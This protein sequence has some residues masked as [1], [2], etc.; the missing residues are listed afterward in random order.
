MELDEL[1]VESVSGNDVS[2]DASSDISA[3]LLNSILLELQNS[4]TRM[5]EIGQQ[6]DDFQ[7]F[8]EEY[9]EA[10]PPHE[11]TDEEK[12]VLEEKEILEL[13][14][15]ETL[16]DLLTKINDNTVSQNALIEENNRLLNSLSSNTVSE[17]S[18]SQNALMTTSLE[19]YSVTD[20]LLLVI[21]AL[22]TVFL[23]ILFMF[24]KEG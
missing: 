11:L 21:V 7:T 10:N 22:L 5:D 12:A 2:S 6:Q 1:N 24:R 13:E 19:D 18:V 4:N 17:N 8:L 16:L 23:T 3:D 20:S 15:R 14:Y 9:L